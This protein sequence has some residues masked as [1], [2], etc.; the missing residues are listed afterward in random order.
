MSADFLLL[1]MDTFYASV[2]QVRRSD[3]R[4]RS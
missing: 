2:E 3:S 4:G 1:D